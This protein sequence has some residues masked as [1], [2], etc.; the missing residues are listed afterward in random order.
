MYEQRKKKRGDRSDGYLIRTRPAMDNIEPFIMRTRNDATNLLEDRVEISKVEEYI[1]ERRKEGLKNFGLMH[2]M[3]ASYVRSVSQYPA[4]NR[5]I[6]G[7]RVYA[8]NKILVCMDIKKEMKLD[9]PDTIIKIEFEPTDTAVD[10]YHRMME[11]INEN[12]GTDSDSDFDGTTEFLV[13]MPRFMFRFFMRLIRFLDYYGKMPK[14][15][16]NISPFHASLF[17]T[18]MGSLGI[19]AIY[20]HLYNFGTVSAFMSIGK[21]YSEYEMTAD[22]TPVKKRYMDYKVSTDERICD[23]YYFAQ[24]LKLMKS[25]YRHPE[26]LS[27][28]PERVIDDID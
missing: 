11:V 15:L 18:S 26:K 3:I 6:A 13:K 8:R 21:K 14:S 27:N 2:F 25:L 22:G 4:V 1:R 28:P 10:V 7:Q 12:K 9:A 19:P 17:F 24:A 5:F 23:G 16:V 20:H